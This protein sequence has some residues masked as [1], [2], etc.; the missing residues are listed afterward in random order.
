MARDRDWVDYANLASNIAQNVQIRDMQHKLGAV[1]SVMQEEKDTAD[2]ENKLRDAVFQSESMLRNLQKASN[3]NPRGSLAWA[4]HNLLQ[5]QRNEVTSGSFRSYEDKERLR[6][7]VEGHE[8][9]IQE[10]AAGLSP[11]QQDQAERCGQ[12]LVERGELDLLIRL[13]QKQAELDRLKAEHQVSGAD[14]RT[15]LGIILGIIALALC[16]IG[17]MLWFI[18]SGMGLGSDMGEP[19]N[20]S[21]GIVILVLGGIGIVV[22]ALLAA[23][24]AQAMEK[25][26]TET[27][28]LIA[29][30]PLFDPV[31]NMVNVLRKAF[32]NASGSA[33]LQMRNDREAVIAD[34]LGKATPLS[35]T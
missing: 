12:Y 1:A 7:V 33:L 6:S 31:F 15:G 11:Q 24:Q 22:A 17:G 30:E 21:A 9:F 28:R 5:F 20:K 27:A 19:E 14:P 26:K 10:C 2:R 18:G 8:Q 3:E 29:D 23:P 35:V 34:V 4:R 32:G 25:L 13:S 16:L